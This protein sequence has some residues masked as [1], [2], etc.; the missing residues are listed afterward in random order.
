MQDV[1]GVGV[2]LAHLGVGTA[3]LSEVIAAAIA[4]DGCTGERLRESQSQIEEL[5]LGPAA[6]I[7]TLKATVG[8]ERESTGGAECED[9][10]RDER[11]GD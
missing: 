9:T 1:A 7:A 8:E 2:G 11:D 3:D 4:V 10:H 6:E 5:G